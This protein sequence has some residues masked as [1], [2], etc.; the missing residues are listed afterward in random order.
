MMSL[1]KEAFMQRP[2]IVCL[3]S[4]LM[5]L[6]GSLPSL[7]LAQSPATDMKP[8]FIS[9]T[10]GLYVNGWP[11]FTVTYPKEWM[12]LRG[13]SGE[14]YRVG[15]IRPGLPPGLHMP[16]FTVGVTAI[17]L[18]LEDWAKVFMPVFVQIWTDIKVLSDKPFR[19]KDGTPARE[20]EVEFV[21]KLH[22][23]LGNLTDAPKTIIYYLLTKRDLAW[24]WVNVI[25]EKARFGEDLKEHVHSLTFLPGREEPVKLPPDVEAFLD[26][27]CADLVS[28]EVT[29]IAG[30]FSDRFLHS[31]MNKAFYEQE[32]RTH[33]DSLPGRC[34][35]TAT[36]F[37][38]HGDRAYVDGFHLDKS[39]DGTDGLKG[40]LV[41]Q[42][43]IKE[44]GQ[45]K[46]F[47]NQKWHD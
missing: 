17:P 21:T 44:Q 6:A 7:T 25:E 11:A 42:Q 15:G 32:F 24:I 14:V 18:S 8:T 29:S 31:G 4:A 3:L 30:H 33:A 39:K 38:T 20:V 28:R 45:W 1:S 36:V 16:I 19:L 37:E 10:P 22:S 43:I 41:F 12:E 13:L 9:P 46:W 40:P 26:M 35:A 23:T 47:G 5:P 27:Y 2:I 34:V